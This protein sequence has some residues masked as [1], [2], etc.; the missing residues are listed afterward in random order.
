M[1][2]LALMTSSGAIF[3]ALVGLR[4]PADTVQIALGLV[5]LFIVVIMVK[6]KKLEYPEF[7]VPDPLSVFL[8]MRGVYL[9]RAADREIAWQVRRTPLALLLFLIIGVMAGVFGI[10][11]LGL[12][13][14]VV[15]LQASIL[16]CAALFIV[17]ILICLGVDQ[18]RGQRAAAEWEA[19]NGR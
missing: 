9:D 3:G 5:I 7:Q 15:G 2:F 1:G 18:A 8:G 19:R 4:L 17:A 14:T 6:A 13:Q 10:V 16:L 11:A 12:L